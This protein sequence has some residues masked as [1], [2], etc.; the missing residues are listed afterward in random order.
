[1]KPSSNFISPVGMGGNLHCPEE[2]AP[3]DVLPAEVIARWLRQCGHSVKIYKGARLVPPD[4]ISIG[5]FSQIDEGV[6]IFAGEEVIIGDRVHF[7]FGSSISG[8]GKCVL[9]DFVGIGAGVRLVTGTEVIDAGGLTNPTVPSEFRTVRRGAIEVGA[10][11]ILF[12]SVVVFPDVRIGEGA[13]VS[14]GSIVHRDLKP[15]AVYAGNP[16]V[17]VGVR[18]KERVLRLAKMVLNKEKPV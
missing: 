8:G 18:E 2:F 10:H 17:Q 7:A 5:N 15:W 4:R 3:G 6:N 12:T 9:D 1:M 14:A 13:V 11:A 16:L